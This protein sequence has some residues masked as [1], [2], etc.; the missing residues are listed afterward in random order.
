MVP[1]DEVAVI[2]F[3]VQCKSKDA[4]QIFNKIYSL[5]FYTVKV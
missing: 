5:A 1:G 2:F 4:V 3:I